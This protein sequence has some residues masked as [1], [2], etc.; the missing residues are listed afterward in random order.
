MEIRRGSP[1]DD[2]CGSRPTE[3]KDRNRRYCRIQKHGGV[4]LPPPRRLAWT[5]RSA[6][7]AELTWRDLPQKSLDGYVDT[8]ARFVQPQQ[9]GH[10]HGAGRSL[11][12]QR[13]G[14]CRNRER[15]ARIER[16]EIRDQ[17]VNRAMPPPGF[18]AAQPG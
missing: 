13:F 9:C 8:K 14:R 16:S 2:R 12:R 7:L 17:L 3:G 5:L 15:V 1:R 18:A 10:S 6:S 11:C 4:S